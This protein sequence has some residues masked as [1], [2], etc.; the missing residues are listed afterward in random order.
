MKKIMLLLAL[1]VVLVCGCSDDE[2]MRKCQEVHSY[3]VC[4][5]LLNR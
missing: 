2:A 1:V 3:D 4:H 5:H